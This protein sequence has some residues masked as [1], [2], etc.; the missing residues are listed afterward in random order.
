MNT[1]ESFRKAK[2]LNI[3]GVW[4]NSRAGF[5]ETDHSSPF[6]TIARVIDSRDYNTVIIEESRIVE[7]AFNVQFGF[8]EYF[9]PNKYDERFYIRSQTVDFVKVQ[10]IRNDLLHTGFRRTYSATNIRIPTA[11]GIV[12]WYDKD[13]WE[14]LTPDEKSLL[15]DL[16]YKDN[17]D[18]V[19]EWFKE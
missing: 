18:S 16:K 1:A 7:N 5:T 19:E 13:A 3:L 6:G 4:M 15:E 14:E 17:K 11:G 9:D 12:K 8:G 10:K 2:L